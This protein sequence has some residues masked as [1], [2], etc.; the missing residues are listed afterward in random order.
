MFPRSR[1]FSPDVPGSLLL[2]VSGL[3]DGENVVILLASFWVS[4]GL[5][6][7]VDQMEGLLAATLVWMNLQ[8]ALFESQF[9]LIQ[10]GILIHQQ[11]IIQGLWPKQSH[12]THRFARYIFDKRPRTWRQRADQKFVCR[13]S[14]HMHQ[15]FSGSDP[16]ANKK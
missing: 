1:L 15:C 12:T 16:K 7:L 9:D 10:C 4:Q 13:I 11:R 6:C 8:R 5:K 14:I 3:P 2:H